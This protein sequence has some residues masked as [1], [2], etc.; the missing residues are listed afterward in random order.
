[1]LVIGAFQISRGAPREQEP[2]KTHVSICTYHTHTHETLSRYC[3]CLLAQPGLFEGMTTRDRLPKAKANH[4]P[5]LPIVVKPE[6]A[7]QL[8]EMIVEHGVVHA[9]IDIIEGLSN[10]RVARN[11]VQRDARRS[12]EGRRVHAQPAKVTNN[13]ATK[14]MRRCERESRDGILRMCLKGNAIL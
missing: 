7:H 11:D 10:D 14:F 12:K 3:F 5:P 13:E 6:H 1:M 8:L 9:C 2:E 4:I